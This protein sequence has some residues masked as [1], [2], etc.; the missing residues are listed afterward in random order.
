ML[1]YP[2]PHLLT[3]PLQSTLAL[4]WEQFTVPIKASSRWE[5]QEALQANSS[6]KV[7]GGE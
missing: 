1:T 5:V 7:G 2:T 4:S 6:L 3:S